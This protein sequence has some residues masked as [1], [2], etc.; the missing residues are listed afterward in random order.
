MRRDDG[1]GLIELVVA[2]AISGIVGTLAVTAIV[3]LHQAARTA[4]SR[5][6]DQAALSQALLRLDGEVRYASSIGA[7]PAGQLWVD[8][9]VQG[10]C[11][12]LR[13][14]GDQLQRRTW[15]GTGASSPWRPIAS[16]VSSAAPFT[17]IDGDRQQLTVD[18]TAGRRQSRITV[19]ALNTTSGTGGTADPCGDAGSRP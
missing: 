16:G 15:T 11:V 12:Q 5:A 18:L 3:Q 17:R 2:M 7:T 8:Y 9:A 14:S 6:T 13:L 10:T 1:F 19:T 4:E